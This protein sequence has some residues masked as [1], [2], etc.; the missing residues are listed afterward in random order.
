MLK[1]SRNYFTFTQELEDRIS[2]LTVIALNPSTPN[3]LSLN[4]RIRLHQLQEVLKLASGDI[5]ELK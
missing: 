3:E 1:D 5:I 2:K 4:V